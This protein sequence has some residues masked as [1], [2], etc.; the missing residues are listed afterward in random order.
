MSRK[1]IRNCSFFSIILVLFF[2]GVQLQG[3]EI[4]VE[5][6]SSDS[7]AVSAAKIT[8]LEFGSK[9]CIPCKMMEEVMEQ[10]RTSYGDQVE[11]IFYDVRNEQELAKQYGIQLIPTQVFLDAEGKEISR[12]QGYYPFKEMDEYLRGI[13]KSDE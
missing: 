3:E 11:V 8:F 6:V 9:G 5:E 2:G 1:L 4:V 7:V 13:V 12:H 10:V